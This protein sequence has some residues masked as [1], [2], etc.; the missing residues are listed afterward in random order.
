MSRGTWMQTF[1][2]GRKL[3]LLRPRVEDV[4]VDDVVHHIARLCRFT[5][6]VRPAIYSVA[7]H[8]VRVSHAVEAHYVALD[9]EKY[10]TPLVRAEC[11]AA[12][13]H[14]AA[15]AY[16]GDVSTPLKRAM[17][18]LSATGVSAFD[19]I[20]GRVERVV[21]EYFGA[22][23]PWSPVVE[24]FDQ[25]LCA[26]EKRDLLAPEPEP[27]VLRAEPLP[28]VI[29]AMSVD[30]AR[31]HWLDRFDLLRTSSIRGWANLF[32]SRRQWLRGSR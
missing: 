2:R 22:M 24:H 31:E 13:V 29:C 12:L 23:Y 8:C 11:M 6:G 1:P 19:D 26:T 3:D 30:A 17:R 5:G 28:D 21:A 9:P 15:E 14:D 16:T 20:S 27:W 32:D 18:E 4:H 10:P 25:V 7:E